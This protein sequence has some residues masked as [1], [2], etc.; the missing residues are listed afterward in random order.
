MIVPFLLQLRKGSTL[1]GKGACQ[2]GHQ[3]LTFA[4]TKP[5]HFTSLFKTKTE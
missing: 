2:E 5:I 3:N 1:M 4:Q